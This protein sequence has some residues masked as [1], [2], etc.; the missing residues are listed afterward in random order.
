VKEIANLKPALLDMKMLVKAGT[1]T[2]LGDYS[3]LW[4]GCPAHK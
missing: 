4:L 3:E 2:P 1:L